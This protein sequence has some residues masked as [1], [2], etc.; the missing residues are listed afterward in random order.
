VA[1]TEDRRPDSKS[2]KNRISYAGIFWT[3][4]RIGLFT[5]GGGLAMATVMRHEIV[6]KRRWVEDDDFM[7]EMAT[8]T[9]VPGAVAVN[10]AFIQGRRL[11][12]GVGA[13]VAILG[14]VL[15]SFCV[16]LAIVWAALPYLS[17]PKVAAFFRGCAIGVAGQIAFTAFVFGRRLLRSWRS[18]VVCAAGAATVVILRVHPLFALIAAVALGYL[19]CARTKTPGGIYDPEC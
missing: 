7:S 10:L 19:L 3:F 4:F 17:R 2:P 13:A 5:L 8:A 6:H 11:R 16:I 9:I 12:G 1:H 15:P 18:V 14:T